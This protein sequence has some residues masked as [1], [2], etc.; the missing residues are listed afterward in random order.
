MTYFPGGGGGGG[1]GGGSSSDCCGHN[2]MD[3]GARGDG[4]SRPLSSDEADNFNSLYGTYGLAVVA[5]QERDFAATQA[6]LYKGANDGKNVYAPAGLYMMGDDDPTLE[7]TATPRT[8]QPTRP[9]LGMIYGDGHDSTEFVWSGLGA[10]EYCMQFIG[11]SNPYAV[12]FHLRNLRIYMDATCDA[13]AICMRAGDCKES[14]SMYRVYLEGANGIELKIAS[15]S[16]YAQMCTNFVECKFDA[17]YGYQWGDNTDGE[18]FSVRPDS[19]G[20]FWDN[21]KFDSC[22]FGGLVFTRAS[23]ASFFNCQFYSNAR[24][25]AIYD[26]CLYAPIGRVNVRDCYFEDYRVAILLTN[27]IYDNRGAT[28][29][30]N[31]FSGTTNDPT[32]PL[33]KHAVQV[34][35]FGV[36]K[37]GT[38]TITDNF[39]NYA[40]YSPGVNGHNQ[41]EPGFEGVDYRLPGTRCIIANNI[42]IYDPYVPPT[43]AVEGCYMQTFDGSDDPDTGLGRTVM[44]RAEVLGVAK[45]GQPFV[46]RYEDGDGPGILWGYGV[47]KYDQSDSVIHG[48]SSTDYTTGGPLGWLG[49]AMACTY[50]PAGSVY[51]WG[52]GISASYYME[53]SAGGLTLA[54]WD[55]VTDNLKVGTGDPNGVHLGKIGDL[56]RNITGGAN[57][58]LWVKESGNGTNTGWVAK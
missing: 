44:T 35:G 53:L 36:N 42:N 32:A 18:F 33:C 23:I 27:G 58:T 25:A 26:G 9:K 40:A 38:Y 6:A 16:S 8:G 19:G 21:V 57:V 10:G 37:L 15:S 13:T 4:V 17:N 12:R 47:E 31:H 5:G 30:G 1:G 46:P 2:I 43:L 45:L 51:R 29:V 24:R 49:N 55:I 52:I 48:F 34:I 14:F 11:E 56:Y 50:I 54:G 28:I 39:G 20:A 3:F 22:E 41:G 7:W